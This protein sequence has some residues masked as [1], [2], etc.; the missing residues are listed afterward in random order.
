MFCLSKQEAV[1]VEFLYIVTAWRQGEDYFVDHLRC[2]DI[3]GRR[4]LNTI[5]QMTEREMTAAFSGT[6]ERIN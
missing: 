4:Y 5:L 3:S 2:Q 1:L 6:L